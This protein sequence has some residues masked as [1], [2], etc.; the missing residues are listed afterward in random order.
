MAF[1]TFRP[2]LP[3]VFVVLLVAG[4]A[5]HRRILVPLVGMAVLAFGVD[6]FAAERVTRLVVIELRRRVLPVLLGMAICAGKAQVS[7][8]F[9]VFLVAGIT[10]GRRFTILGFG[11][12]AG[13]ALDLLGVGMGSLEREVRPLVIE[14][15]V[16]HRSDIFRSSL[17]LRVAFLTVPLLFEP[18]VEALLLL[19]VLADV[20]VAILAERILRPFVEAFVTFGAVFFPFGM[21]FDHLPWHQRRFKTVGPCVPAVPATD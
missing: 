12:V 15:L 6:V 5:I 11:R 16:R 10:V 21:A 14:R 17:M 9:V 19:D 18:S 1:L 7:F 2:L 4:E 20:F 13:L 3:F 8:V